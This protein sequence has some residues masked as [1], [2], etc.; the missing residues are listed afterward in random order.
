MSL[1]QIFRVS[2]KTDQFSRVHL[3]ESHSSAVLCRVCRAGR[4]IYLRLSKLV[5]LWSYKSCHLRRQGH[6]SACRFVRVQST[7]AICNV[8]AGMLR[9]ALLPSARA[10]ETALCRKMTA[11]DG[12]PSSQTEF[13]PPGKAAKHQTELEQRFRT[14]TGLHMQTHTE[15]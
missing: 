6:T 13:M 5:C 9:T 4:F 10:R 3:H 15:T 7:C 14:R 12:N 1:T 11:H 2:A 8:E